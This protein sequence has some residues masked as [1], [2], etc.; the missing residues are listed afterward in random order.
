MVSFSA[1]FVELLMGKMM[2]KTEY[3]KAFMQSFGSSLLT[4][5]MFRALVTI[6]WVCS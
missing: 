1:R 2:A 4:D 5:L 3:V 6:L